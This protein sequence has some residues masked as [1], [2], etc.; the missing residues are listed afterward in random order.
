MGQEYILL[1]NALSSL[2]SGPI[3]IISIC[4]QIFIALRQLSFANSL[5]ASNCINTSP[6][7]SIDFSCRQYTSTACVCSSL[8]C[9]NSW[10]VDAITFTVI[11]SISASWLNSVPV[12][13]PEPDTLLKP[14]PL[15]LLVLSPQPPKI[16][17]A[18]IDTDNNNN[19]CLL[20]IYFTL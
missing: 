10:Y 6:A 12:S 9:K 3:C 5:S 18:F 4:C 16:T 17:A 20:N 14:S 2:E 19:F 13:F 11:F 1:R 15:E 8:F 7:N